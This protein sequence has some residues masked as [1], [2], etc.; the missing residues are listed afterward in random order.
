MN[1]NVTRALFNFIARIWCVAETIHRD[2]ITDGGPRVFADVLRGDGPG[3][4]ADILWDGVRLLVDWV[5]TPAK[6]T[7]QAQS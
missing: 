7:R 1:R 6:Q 2:A 4:F 3:V 5:S